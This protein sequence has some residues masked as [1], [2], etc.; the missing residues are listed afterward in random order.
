M[1]SEKLYN[2]ILNIDNINDNEQYSK[3]LL[4]QCV[5]NEELFQKLAENDNFI[6]TFNNLLIDHF[7]DFDSNIQKIVLLA[8]ARV[9]TG[10]D[11]FIEANEEIKN[12]GNFVE[13]LANT[14]LKSVY[15]EDKAAVWINHIAIYKVLDDLVFDNLG[16]KLL[17]D[18]TFLSKTKE[19]SPI[20]YILNA[21]FLNVS[22][23]ELKKFFRSNPYL[24]SYMPDKMMN[25]TDFLC[26]IISLLGK[27][28][29]W[30]LS[31]LGLDRLRNKEVKK[32]IINTFS[33]EVY[34]RLVFNRLEFEK[35]C[36]VKLDY[37]DWKNLVLYSPSS[38]DYK[39][40]KDLN[41][42]SFALSPKKNKLFK[43]IDSTSTITFNKIDTPELLSERLYILSN[44][45]DMNLKKE[46]IYDQVAKNWENV[47][48]WIND[49]ND[50][51]KNFNDDLVVKQNDMVFFNIYNLL[52]GIKSGKLSE[53]FE[54]FDNNDLRGSKYGRFIENLDVNSFDKS[55]IKLIGNSEVFSSDNKTLSLLND[56]FLKYK[57]ISGNPYE[58]I[59]F[60][61]MIYE[62]EN[63]LNLLINSDIEKLDSKILLNLYT[64]V[65]SCANYVY[66]ISSLND[67]NEIDAIINKVISSLS[68]KRQMTS[69]ERYCCNKF[70]TTYIES[71]L[72][73]KDDFTFNEISAKKSLI[74]LKYFNI[75]LEYAKLIYHSY[76]SSASQIYNQMPELEIIKDQLKKIVESD[77]ME[78]L[79]IIDQNLNQNNFHFTFA[80]FNRLIKKIKK[81]YG[82][83]INNTL[84]T[85][86]QNGIVDITENNFGLI[87]HVLGAYGSLPPGDVYSSWNTK[88]KNDN[89]SICTSYIT[90]N[91]M[92][93]AK[94][95]EDSVIL[96]FNNLPNDFLELMSNTDLISKNFKAIKG[97]NFMSPEELENKTRHTHNELTIRRMMGEYSDEKIQPSY[98]ICFDNI[99]EKSKKTANQ[100]GIPIL[101]ID[102]NKIALKNYNNIKENLRS[103]GQSLDSSLISKIIVGQ[104][105]NRS[106]LR[107]SRPDL[108]EKYYSKEIRQ[109]NINSIYNIIINNLENPNIISC[110]NEF[111]NVLQDEASKYEEEDINERENYYDIE[112]EDMIN[113]LKDKIKS[114][115]AENSKK[116]LSKQDVQERF[117][118]L[119]KE[120]EEKEL[121][122]LDALKKHS[123][124]VG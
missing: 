111:I 91:N 61:N 31:D 43:A 49:I 112:Y 63:L 53:L 115:I 57:V 114:N 10:V 36:F 84:I 56:V 62:D 48:L 14:Y 99:N 66:K 28:N 13:L 22:K 92:G 68:D 6:E 40:L 54:L 74:L 32:V 21:D 104:E 72:N 16:D 39:H 29:V 105:N 98:I 64:Y 82:E 96:G 1:G 100:F 65:F 94:C 79:N 18:K 116:N 30:N 122:E 41:K 87:V 109:E 12:D 118:L 69:F 76:F 110:M 55:Y 33:Q 106:G 102:R 44:A 15:K 23:E 83:M 121:Q 107:M 5:K 9:R 67:L 17:K 95:S 47:K 25:D 90:N 34:S 88:E 19:F 42:F 24:I 45:F 38:I 113:N 11:I 80:D 4:I 52:I 26:E 117:L 7:S 89:V 3:S 86:D 85:T 120:L 81:E 75:N 78:E 124:K 60:I 119:R 97:C 73:D 35:N 27:N 20:T 71:T 70:D 101:F 2:E 77:T 103:F 51:Y 108:V 8:F 59:Q 37:K 50:Y 93:I 46:Y 58:T 123:K